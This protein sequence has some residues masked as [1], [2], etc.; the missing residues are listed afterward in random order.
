MK[1]QIQ[2]KNIVLTFDFSADLATRAKKLGMKYRPSSKEWWFENNHI[3]KMLIAREFDQF[4]GFVLPEPTPTY[5]L[6]AYL[7]PHQKKAVMDA[8]T[9]KRLGIYYDTGVGKTLSAIEIIRMYRVKTLV[10]CPLSIIEPAWMVDLEKWSPELRLNATNL[11]KCKTKKRFDKG[12]ESDVCIINFESFRAKAKQLSEAE[13]S[14]VIIDESSRA[15]NPKSSVTKA[16]V[17]FCDNIPLVYLLSG[18]PA[19][20]N[21]TEYWP[22]M[23]ILDPSLLSRSFYSFRSKYFTP[24][25]FGGFQWKEN[26]SVRQDLL[27]KI[28]TVSIVARKED[29]L[30]LPERTDRTV[31]VMLSP[32]E[33]RA[34]E[35]MK[36]DMIVEVEENEICASNAAVKYMKLRSITSGFMFDEDRN[37]HTVGKSKL[38]ALLELLEQIGDHQVIIWTTFQ[39]EARAI[40]EALRNESAICNG[41]VKQ[42][43]K[44]EAIKDFKDGHIKYLI[45]HPKT[46]GHGV[47]LTNCTYSIYYSLSYS[48]EE[49]SQSRDRIYR[50][51]QEN[52]CTYYH[53]IAQNTVDRPILEALRGKGDASDAVLKYIKGGKKC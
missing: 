52:K 13:F 32:D 48:Y 22:Q 8:R 36:D 42:S 15:K 4:L 27:D 44:E 10:V 21:N 46:I 11:W 1:A 2:G 49:Y 35:Q 45:A 28:A 24:A 43:D 23:R 25:G 16:L 5:N 47:T 40:S 14:M 3:N 53:L 7:M 26:P 29:V 37:V 33:R 19:P 38:K 41:T 31:D 18:T 9:Y 50:K 12:L 39:Y 17:K 34:Y 30:E 6:P 20:N 51:G